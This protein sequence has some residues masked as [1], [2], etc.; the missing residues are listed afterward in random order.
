MGLYTILDA[1]SLGMVLIID[2]QVARLTVEINNNRPIIDRKGLDMSYPNK[3]N[4]M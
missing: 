2:W 1:F 4:S 3:H